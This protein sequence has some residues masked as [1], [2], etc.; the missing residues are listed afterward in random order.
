M[1]EQL[2]LIDYWFYRTSH[3]L[4]L[5]KTI[6]FSEQLTSVVFADFSDDSSQFKFTGNGNVPIRPKWLRAFPLCTTITAI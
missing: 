3:C 4:T 6:I 5:P 1:L 2:L